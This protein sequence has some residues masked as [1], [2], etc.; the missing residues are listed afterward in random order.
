MLIEIYLL[1]QKLLQ[2]QKKINLKCKAD[3]LM[4]NILLNYTVETNIPL[5]S[6]GIG[7]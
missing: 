3:I 5:T 7:L 2:S 6:K 1:K 4:Q